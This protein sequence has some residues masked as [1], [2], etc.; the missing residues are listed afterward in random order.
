MVHLNYFENN[1]FAGKMIVNTQCHYVQRQQRQLVLYQMVN[2]GF[3]LLAQNIAQR[4]PGAHFS[5]S[6]IVAVAKVV[7]VLCCYTASPV[8]LKQEKALLVN[9]LFCTTS[10]RRRI[11]KADSMY[12]ESSYF[13]LNLKIGGMEEIDLGLYTVVLLQVPRMARKALSKL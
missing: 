3:V 12:L 5:G 13:I 1:Y 9:S 10:S 4:T 2:F 8:C 11:S 7:Y 6:C